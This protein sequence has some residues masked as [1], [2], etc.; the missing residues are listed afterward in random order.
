[1]DYR[2]LWIYRYQMTSVRNCALW[3]EGSGAPQILSG[4][5]GEVTVLADCDLGQSR[6]RISY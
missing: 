6:L 5:C 1:M 2:I 3:T 4:T